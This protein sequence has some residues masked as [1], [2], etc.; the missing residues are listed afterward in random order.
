MQLPLTTTKGIV[1]TRLNS[2]TTMDLINIVK[3]LT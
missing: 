2:A 1:L 3:N